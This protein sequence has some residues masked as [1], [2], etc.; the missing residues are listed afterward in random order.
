MSHAVFSL[1]ATDGQHQRE[2]WPS[3]LHKGKT[4]LCNHIT[5]LH[6]TRFKGKDATPSVPTLNFRPVWCRS[7]R[8]GYGISRSRQ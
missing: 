4:G 1:S 8:G 2:V 7:L 5:L 6:V 3:R